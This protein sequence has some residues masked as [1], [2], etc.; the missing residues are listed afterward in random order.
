MT[1]H[2]LIDKLK[3][4]LRRSVDAREPEGWGIPI[5]KADLRMLI[6]AIELEPEHHHLLAATH[7]LG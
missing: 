4:D 3:A 1:V 2:D 6:A 5:S 7:A